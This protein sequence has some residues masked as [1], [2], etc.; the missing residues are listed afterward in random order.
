MLNRT[1]SPAISGT[2]GTS[3]TLIGTIPCAGSILSMDIANTGVVALTAFSVLARVGP[4]NA[5][6]TWLSGT[7]WAS[8]GKTAMLGASAGLLTLAGGAS[9]F[10]HIKVFGCYD[11]QIWATVGSA[12]TGVTVNP[13]F[14]EAT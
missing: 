2:A 6:Q 4:T 9:G 1:I 14:S 3:L 10:A 5:Y 11:V 7:D 8:T 12:T 13:S